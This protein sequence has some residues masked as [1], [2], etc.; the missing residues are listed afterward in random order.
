M[1]L[2][3]RSVVAE[4]KMVRAADR[5]VRP[6]IHRKTIINRLQVGP[7]LV[8]LRVGLVAV[9][10]QKDHEWPVDSCLN[11]TAVG[12]AVHV[13]PCLAPA[14]FLAEFEGCRTSEGMPKNSYARHV[15]PSRELAG[16]IRRVQLL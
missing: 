3:Q 11:D 9:V 14:I 5:D 12:S 4:G 13:D 2:Q 15:Q 8:G 10:T 1:A 7:D 6:S 16:C